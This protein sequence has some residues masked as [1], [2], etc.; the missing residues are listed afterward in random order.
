MQI[1]KMTTFH[2]SIV[3]NSFHIRFAK[4]VHSEFL[5]F[6]GPFWQFF[7]EG[8]KCRAL[9]E[10]RKEFQK[11]IFVPRKT[12][13]Q[14]QKR[15]FFRVQSGKLTVS[16]SISTTV[17]TLLK[18]K[19]WKWQKLSTRLS[20][21]FWDIFLKMIGIQMCLLTSVPLHWKLKIRIWNCT[22]FAV[23]Y[24]EKSGKSYWNI[25]MKQPT[26]WIRS[27]KVCTYNIFLSQ[28]H[29]GKIKLKN[30]VFI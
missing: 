21:S 2:Q 27:E 22:N 12:G 6:I 9:L 7:R 15:H 20:T 29:F 28:F 3:E 8:W 4:L 24:P 11:Y 26:L 5:G 23:T 17:V 19:H 16:P 1:T 30:L 13:R 10:S 25:A 14:N 18:A